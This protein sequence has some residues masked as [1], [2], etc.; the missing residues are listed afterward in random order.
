MKDDS[1]LHTGHLL[2]L[3]HRDLRDT[4]SVAQESREGKW[5]YQSS[6]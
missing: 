3:L 4:Q 1:Q 2:D 6:G 5:T